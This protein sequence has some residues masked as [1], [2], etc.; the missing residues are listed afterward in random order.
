MAKLILKKALT[1]HGFVRRFSEEVLQGVAENL[2]ITKGAHRLMKA[3][4]YYGYKT[5]ILSGVYLG[6][7]LQKKNWD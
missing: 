5:A 2:P 3:L 7:Y 1:A 4:K 6:K